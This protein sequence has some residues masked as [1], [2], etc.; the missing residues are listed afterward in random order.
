MLE[1]AKNL[2]AMGFA[3]HW[4]HTKSKR[5]IGDDWSIKPVASVSKLTSSY[6][7]GYNLGCRPGEWSRVSGY[8][9]HIIDMDVRDPAHEREARATLKELL[10][11]LDQATAP[12][13]VS[14][15]GG[16]S[17]HFYLLTDKPFP[18]RKFAHSPSF[19][20]VWSNEKQKDVK[21]WD[22]ELHLLGTGANAVLPP[23]IHPETGKPY[24]WLIEFDPEEVD[25]GIIREIPADAIERIVGT[26]DPKDPERTQPL[27]YT[28]WQM[29]QVLDKLPVEEWI[30]DRDGWYRMGMAIHHETGGSQEGFD[31]WCEYSRKSKKFDP[32]DSRYVWRSFKNNSNNPFRFASLNA[33]VRDMALDDEID[34]LDALDEPE[35]D[36]FDDVLGSPKPSKSQVK[37]AKVEV[38]H[39][40]KKEAPDW[41]KRLNKRHALARVSSK[42]V[43]MDFQPDGRVTYGTVS[44]LHNFYENERRPKDNTTVPVTKLWMQHKARRDYP[45]GIVFLPNQ[46]VEG[47]YNHWQGFSVE[48]NPNASCSLFL[49]HL[50]EVFCDGNSD[51]YEYMLKW[52]AHCVQFPEDKPGVAVVAKGQKGAGKDT[53]FE[54][55]GLLFRHHYITIANKDQMVGKFNR[56]QE[57]CLLLHVQEGFWGGDKRDEGSLKYL[58][59]SHDVMIEPKG[60]DAFPVKSVLRLFISSN[61]RWVVPATED[62]RRFFVMNVNNSRKGDHAYFDALRQE[63]NG[64]GP[65]A[66]LHLLQTLD[67]TNFQV[68]DVPDTEG[69]AEQKV[70]GFKNV[71]AWWFNALQTGCIH[72]AE[73]ENTIHHD[74]WSRNYIRVPVADFREAY[75]LWMRSRRFD[76]DVC[77]EIELGK[78]FQRMLPNVQRKRAKN[79]T[80]DG[81]VYTLPDLN[82]CREQFEKF[83]G[84]RID[85]PEESTEPDED[86]DL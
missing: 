80:V 44:D 42:T 32:K 17:R 76:G 27:G 77:G 45:N 58:I 31:L 22:W 14:G 37:L 8:Y 19:Q 9:M 50:R 52:M 10:P 21:K 13:V 69:L 36:L 82:S 84:S 38:E 73:K 53:V 60:I 4:L 41:V 23:S 7:E 34:D 18:S 1:Q 54:Y 47:A 72:A 43:V 78:R 59:T 40:L 35:D 79:R 66:L 68:R 48:P 51:Y 62:E 83:I 5:P 55:F 25:L 12:C 67:L 39:K 15:S 65:A 33:V 26:T 16:A 71:E 81:Y 49:K 20:M 86:D 28:E 2:S 64:S 6:R 29:R 24:R 56:H 11:E 57:K 85:W 3:L 63:M 61:E 74:V 75:V 70:Q 46:E 30:E